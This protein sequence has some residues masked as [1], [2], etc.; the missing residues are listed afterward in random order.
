MSFQISSEYPMPPATRGRGRKYP[1]KDLNIGQSFEVH[2]LREIQNLRSSVQY[3]KRTYC[4]GMKFTI[5]STGNNSA[6]C[7]RIQ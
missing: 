6:R 4:E 3:A 1:L 7:W 5:R 2:G